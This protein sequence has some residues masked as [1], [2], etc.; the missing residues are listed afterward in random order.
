MNCVEKILQL[1]KFIDPKFFLIRLSSFLKALTCQ[2]KS[3]K[4]NFSPCSFKFR[5]LICEVRS[6]IKA[7]FHTNLLSAS[8]GTRQ[9]CSVINMSTSSRSSRKS[10]NTCST[11]KLHNG[12]E[13][14]GKDCL[15]QQENVW[16]G[17][18]WGNWIEWRLL[19]WQL[20]NTSIYVPHKPFWWIMQWKIMNLMPPAVFTELKCFQLCTR[21]IFATICS[22]IWIWFQMLEIKSKIRDG[23]RFTLAKNSSQVRLCSSWLSCVLFTDLWGKVHLNLSFQFHFYLELSCF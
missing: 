15:L 5:N 14:L 23:W 2:Y 18:V 1:S 7:N 17:I 6:T 10:C 21:H 16:S 12:K 19:F 8:S 20:H 9:R 13:H 11:S 22:D 4:R 3:Q